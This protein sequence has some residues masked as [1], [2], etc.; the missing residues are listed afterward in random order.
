MMKP[1]KPKPTAPN[2]REKLSANL[3]RALEEDF[4]ANGVAAL[5][6]MRLA[7]PERYC[8]LA[9]KL[10]AQSEPP[11]PNDVNNAK[12]SEDLMRYALAKMGIANPSEQQLEMAVAA[13]TRFMSELEMIAAVDIAMKITQ[14]EY[15]E[16]ELRS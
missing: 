10:I 4:A 9:A 16:R 12:S 6:K 13:N 7:S 8:E 3:L 14:K 2:L 1:R 11:D 5:E 15:E